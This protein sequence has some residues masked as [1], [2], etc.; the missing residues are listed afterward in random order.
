MQVTSTI[1]INTPRSLEDGFSKLQQS[2]DGEISRVKHL[3]ETY[4]G[5]SKG[6]WQLLPPHIPEFQHLFLEP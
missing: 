6:T 3:E 4:Q 5:H 2:L 1:Q